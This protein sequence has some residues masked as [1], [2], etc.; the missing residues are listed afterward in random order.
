[1]ERLN[2]RRREEVLVCL[3]G[4][5]LQFWLCGDGWIASNCECTESPCG[6]IFVVDVYTQLEEIPVASDLVLRLLQ[7]H[8][9][10][11]KV[12]QSGQIIPEIPPSCKIPRRLPANST[13]YVLQDMK[14]AF[15]IVIKDLRHLVEAE[16]LE[17]DRLA[18]LSNSCC[19]SHSRLA[20]LRCSPAL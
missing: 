4:S 10:I 8:T 11:S 17:A 5:Q 3:N 2:L 15:F 7:L 6:T 1:V 14:D 19:C 18:N 20:N 12:V 16:S 13:D 9:R